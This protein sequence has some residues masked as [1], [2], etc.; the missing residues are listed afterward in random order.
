MIKHILILAGLII[1]NLLIPIKK[2][3]AQTN[4]FYTWTEFNIQ[5]KIAKGFTLSLSP[6]IR[7]HNDFSVDEVFAELGLQYR[8]VK[9]LKIAANYRLTNNIKSDGSSSI[10]HRFAFDA[11]SGLDPGRMSIQ[12]RI[13]YTNYSDFDWENTDNAVHLRY[14]IKASYDIKNIKLTPFVSAEFFQDIDNKGNNKLRLSTGLDYKLFKNNYL[15]ISYKTHQYLAKDNRNNI[16]S[17]NYKIT[18]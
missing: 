15:G 8:L 17:V 1:L 5:K 9:Y 18:L 11:K 12:F 2:T 14:R 3:E 7:F 4:N 10:K 16:I 13:R 6:E